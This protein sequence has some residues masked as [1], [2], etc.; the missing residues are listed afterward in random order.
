MPIV[1]IHLVKGRS[2]EQKRKLAE[3]VTAALTETIGVPKD[4]V[5]ILLHELEVDNVAQGGMLFADSRK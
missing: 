4:T 5:E 1:Q 3:K 2:I